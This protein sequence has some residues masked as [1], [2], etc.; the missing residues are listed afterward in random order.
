[1]MAKFFIT[2][3]RQ[4]TIRTQF[5]VEAESEGEAKEKA[6]EQASWDNPR[7]NRNNGI[8]WDSD[9]T[10]WIDATNPEVTRVVALD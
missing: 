7:D 10:Q 3:N 1:M 5:D 2:M 9:Q 8:D 6:L 4:I